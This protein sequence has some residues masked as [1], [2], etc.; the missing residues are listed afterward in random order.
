MERFQKIMQYAY[1]VIA[2][3]LFVEGIIKLVGNETPKGVIM[4]IFA[5][6]AV[7]MYFFKKRFRNRSRFK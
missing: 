1:L 2:L 5:F 3:V 6:L 7:F 4:L